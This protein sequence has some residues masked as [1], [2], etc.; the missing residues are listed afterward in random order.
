V[1]PT[2]DDFEPRRDGWYEHA[3]VWGEVTV[4]TVLASSKRSERWEVISTAHPQQIQYGYTLWFR[5]REQ[6]TGE[7]H[8][9][10][11]KPKVFKVSILTQDPRDTETAP[12]TDPTDSAAIALLVR[13]LGA[14]VL[15]TRDDATGE[16]HCPDYTDGTHITTGERRVYRGLIEHMRFAHRMSVDDELE[17]VNAITVHGQAH[18]PQWPNIGKAGFSHRHVP[19]DLSLMG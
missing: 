3:G 4:G 19:E 9:V 8:S 15:A 11:P 14:E 1:K 5:I 12:S 2:S 7:E 16:V 17:L 18:N 13:E 10:A 6:S